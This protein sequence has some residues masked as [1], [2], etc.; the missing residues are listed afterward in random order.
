MTL[1]SWVDTVTQVQ[2]S[3]SITSHLPSPSLPSC[4][5]AWPPSPR[6]LAPPGSGWDQH[7]HQHWGTSEPDVT[8]MTTRCPLK[9]CAATEGMGQCWPTW[10]PPSAV[11]L[12]R[13]ARGLGISVCTPGVLWQAGCSQQLGHSNSSIQQGKVFC[14]VVLWLYQLLSSQH[15]SG[16]QV[17]CPFQVVFSYSH[18]SMPETQPPPPHSPHPADTCQGSPI[19]SL[20]AW[21]THT[22]LGLQSLI[23]WSPT[24]WR[25]SQDP[26]VTSVLALQPS[27]R[28]EIIFQS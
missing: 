19:P 12:R 5:L 2:V 3:P 14:W 23:P 22:Y 16:W 18:E 15:F 28:R 8:V 1:L 4:P 13:A 11:S 7:Q 24:K 6:S 25:H 27:S 9:P 21:R 17:V 10:H 26:G 20:E